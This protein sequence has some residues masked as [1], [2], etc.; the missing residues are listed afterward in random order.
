MDAEPRHPAHHLRV[1]L[2][3]QPGRQDALRRTRAE[4][5]LHP[6]PGDHVRAGGRRRAW[7]SWSCD[8]ASMDRLS[9]RG[10]GSRL[11][12]MLAVAISSAALAPAM[13]RYRVGPTSMLLTFANIRLGVW[14]PNPRY[15]NQVTERSHD[16]A[17]DPAGLPVQGVLRLPRPV[18]PLRVPHRRRALGEHRPGGAA[19]EGRLPRDRLRRRGPRPGRRG[20]VDLRGHRPGRSL[21]CGAQVHLD[22]DPLRA[23]RALPGLRSTPGA[24]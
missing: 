10:N 8:T 6:G 11:T 1:L 21:E 14:M 18:G 24:R 13:G 16:A 12:T 20:E 23:E 15:V 2:G 19:P 22:L 3:V 5:D 7:R 4:H 17:G 9:R